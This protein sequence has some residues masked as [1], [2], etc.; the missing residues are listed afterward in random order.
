M[1]KQTHKIILTNEQLKLIRQIIN[2]QLEVRC[3]NVETIIIE[4]ESMIKI[5]SNTFQTIPVLHSNLSITNFGGGIYVEGKKILVH[6]PVHVTYDGN[7]VTLFDLR[8]E[9]LKND[10]YYINTTIQ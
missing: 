9:L 3:F 10:N 1:T 6:V 8:I 7:G 4:K 5:S 2:S